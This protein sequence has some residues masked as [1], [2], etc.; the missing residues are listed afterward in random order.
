MDPGRIQ[1]SS[2]PTRFLRRLRNRPQEQMYGGVPSSAPS[3]YGGNSR[4]ASN[5]HYSNHPPSGQDVAYP[6]RKKPTLPN[7]APSNH[8]YHAAALPNSSAAPPSHA[9]GM[10]SDNGMAAA[11]GRPPQPYY[12]LPPRGRACASFPV[13]DLDCRPVQSTE[14]GAVDGCK[15]GKQD[16]GGKFLPSAVAMTEGHLYRRT[17]RGCLVLVCRKLYGSLMLRH[18]SA[19]GL[20]VKGSWQANYQATLLSSFC[21]SAAPGTAGEEEGIGST[22]RR[23]EAAP[24]FGSIDL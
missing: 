10:P 19:L 4:Q 7:S 20:S 16:G 1:R 13:G 8:F 3:N 24:G 9:Y 2:Q 11:P 22:A 6:A 21:Q 5:G 12:E 15:R 23:G 14:R 18:S 17:R